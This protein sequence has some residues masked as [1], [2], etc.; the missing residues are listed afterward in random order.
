DN[1]R[2]FEALGAVDGHHSHFVLWAGEFALYLAAAAFDRVEEGL[3]AGR[4]AGVERGG[5][6]DEGG[7][8]LACGGAEAREDQLPAGA[9]Q[10]GAALE[11]VGE[12][13]ERR[14]VPA[15]EDVF[16]E[17]GD[18]E[19][20]RLHRGPEATGAWVGD[21]EK[22]IVIEAAKGTFEDFGERQIIFGA[23]RK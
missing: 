17:G 7:D 20:R 1:N 11:R 3:K 23:E 15:G 12:E 8:G 2:R 4:L 10:A 18:G 22:L 19:V 9:G 14:L 5:A 16:E 13:F 6:V 21:G